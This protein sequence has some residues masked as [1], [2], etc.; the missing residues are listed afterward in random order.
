MSKASLSVPFMLGLE[1][2]SEQVKSEMSIQGSIRT[3]SVTSR[4][5]A[6]ATRLLRPVYRALNNFVAAII[7]ERE[8]QANVAVLRGLSDRELADMGLCRYQIDGGLA[9]AARD[10]ARLQK[11]LAKAHDPAGP[12]RG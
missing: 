4:V 11:E 7:A 1:E 2:K 6:S 5:T 10:R 8:R 9:E 3:V 12:G